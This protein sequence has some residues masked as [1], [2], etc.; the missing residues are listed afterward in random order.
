M[1]TH[2]TLRTCEGKKFNLRLLAVDTN[3]LNKSNK[4]DDSTRAHPLPELPSNMGTRSV[5]LPVFA[6]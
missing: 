4:R 6:A 1:V 3:A 5:P 2:N